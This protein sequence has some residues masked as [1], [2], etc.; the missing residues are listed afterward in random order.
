MGSSVDYD[1]VALL[2]VFVVVLVITLAGLFVLRSVQRSRIALNALAKNVEILKQSAAMVSQ[3]Y[4]PADAIGSPERSPN[5]PKR[6]TSTSS[7]H[8]DIVW[9][10]PK[11]IEQFPVLTDD[12]QEIGMSQENVEWA[13]LHPLVKEVM[14]INGH[15]F[16]LDRRSKVEAQHIMD[17]FDYAKTGLIP[18]RMFLWGLGIDDPTVVAE[19]KEQDLPHEDRLLR[20]FPAVSADGQYE[21]EMSAEQVALALIDP[22]VMEVMGRFGHR[23][24]QRG[25]GA[26]DVD[27]VM[28][29]FDTD[30]TG[31]VATRLFLWGLGVD[32]PPTAKSARMKEPS[33][34]DKNAPIINDFK[35]LLKVFHTMDIDGDGSVSMGEMQVALQRPEFQRVMDRLGMTDIQLLTRLDR[36]G[37]GVITVMEFLD[38]MGPI[39]DELGLQDDVVQLSAHVEIK[40]KEPLIKDAKNLF[41]AFQGMDVDGDG[42]VNREELE[43]TVSQPMFARILREA[44]LDTA[45]LMVRLDANQDNSISIMEFL[46][47]MGKLLDDLGLQSEAEALATQIEAKAKKAKRYAFRRSS[48]PVD[49]TIRRSIQKGSIK[50]LVSQFNTNDGPAPRPAPR[51]R[52]ISLAELREEAERKPPQPDA[53]GPVEPWS[54]GG[55]RW[56]GRQKK[57]D[58]GQIGSAF[59]PQLGL[60]RPLLVD[61]SPSLAP[62]GRPLLEVED[63]DEWLEEDGPFGFDDDVGP[64][65][66]VSESEAVA[67][68]NTATATV[69]EAAG[70]EQADKTLQAAKTAAAERRDQEDEAARAAVALAA[71]Q[72]AAAITLQAVARGHLARKLARGKL[73]TARELAGLFEACSLMN[74]H[75][76]RVSRAVLMAEAVSRDAL[77]A[78]IDIVNLIEGLNVNSQ[79]EVSLVDFVRGMEEVVVAFGGKAKASELLGQLAAKQQEELAAEREAERIESERMERSLQLERAADRMRAEQRAER[80]AKAKAEQQ[81]AADAVKSRINLARDVARQASGGTE[82]GKDVGDG[83]IFMA[84]Q[85]MDIDGDGKVTRAEFEQ[86]AIKPVVAMALARTGLQAG[87]LM[88]RLDTS[89]NGT[90]EVIELL[91]GMKLLTKDG[92]LPPAAGPKLAGQIGGSRP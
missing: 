45:E 46:N 22:Y 14:R 4:Y 58:A 59:R 65:I 27:D 29:L 61:G 9:A 69:A 5:S 79:G 57:A 52:P 18:A 23:F 87:E 80:A 48:Q 89:G 92:G 91:R 36:N 67:A 16:S 90:L 82:T 19:V 10:A 83:Q 7:L 63:D 53:A 43:G 72:E 17:L 13:L 8:Q 71:K 26:V 33:T 3:H 76:G 49:E 60:P 31:S 34:R 77:L 20:L 54:S 81:A 39:V 42:A 41:K 56:R 74:I 62:G 38:A 37:D 84:F 55:I 78:E 35:N 15:R 50:T 85:T 75:D 86:A 30:K 24:N 32:N 66:R 25:V 12:N 40:R 47:G 51:S 2:L 70:A 73:E 11:L 44:K 1:A 64:A 6:R 28:L 68:F 88:D 21:T